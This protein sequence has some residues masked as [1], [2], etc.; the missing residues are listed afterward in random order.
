MRRVRPP[1]RPSPSSLCRRGTE[2]VLPRAKNDLDDGLACP[3][4][5]V[6]GEFDH[7]GSSRT[8]P[9]LVQGPYLL[10]CRTSRS[11]HAVLHSIET[12]HRAA[13]HV[14]RLFV[15]GRIRDLA[16]DAV[17]CPSSD[18][19][20]YLRGGTQIEKPL[21]ARTFQRHQVGPIATTYGANAF[22]PL[23]SALTTGSRENSESNGRY[24]GEPRQLRGAQKTTPHVG[25]GE[26]ISPV[27]LEIGR[28]LLLDRRLRLAHEPSS[29]SYHHA[30]EPTWRAGQDRSTSAQ[31]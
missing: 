17:E 20:P 29:R 27:A 16:G 10:G 23:L 4:T 11:V 9:L 6:A 13:V 28:S 30:R 15:F 3:L 2:A 7:Y 14:S 21:A 31:H 25:G 1:R 8:E 19:K 18:P 5:G 22:S 12:I 24:E 26:G